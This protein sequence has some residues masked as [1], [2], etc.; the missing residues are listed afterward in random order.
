MK[1]RRVITAIVF[2]FIMLGSL[3]L[4]DEGYGK[5]LWIAAMVIT[6]G[7]IGY[8]IAPLLRKL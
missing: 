5:Q 3:Y 6:A 4:I 1:K 7:F 8:F 2:M